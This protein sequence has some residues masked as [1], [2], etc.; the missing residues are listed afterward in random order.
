MNENKINEILQRWSGFTNIS[1]DQDPSLVNNTFDSIAFPMVMKVAARSLAMG[2]WYK[3]KI[4]QLKEDRLNKLK[5]L[6]GEEP[7][8]ILPD[9]EYIDGL[10]SVQP[11]SG[12]SGMLTYLDF[13][14]ETKKKKTRIGKIIDIFK[15]YKL[16]YIQ[17]IKK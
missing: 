11:L 17:I 9:D 15:R 13:K 16:K 7:N 4:Q 8:I 12:P 14:Y 1:N 6:I 5:K 3:S 10:V 2:G